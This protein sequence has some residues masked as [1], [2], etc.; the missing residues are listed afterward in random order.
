M[1]RVQSSVSSDK[2]LSFWSFQREARTTNPSYWV[3]RYNSLSAHRYT[4]NTQ[5]TPTSKNFS[6]RPGRWAATPGTLFGTFK[7]RN[8][9]QDKNS[10]I[11]VNNKNEIFLGLFGAI[12]DAS[13]AA[14]GT[15]VSEIERHVVVCALT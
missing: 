5:S 8:H 9:Q 4:S 15:R 7:V 10:A 11:G 14:E 13:T 3:T 2:F 12:G 6:S 1:S